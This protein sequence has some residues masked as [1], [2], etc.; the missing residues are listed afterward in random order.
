MKGGVWRIFGEWNES[1]L[2]V[3]LE[4]RRRFNVN[5]GRRE[6]YANKK[7]EK[8]TPLMIRETK[9]ETRENKTDSHTR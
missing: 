6:E 8:K 5:D 7:C 4:T 1:Y 3:L 2:L 9:K